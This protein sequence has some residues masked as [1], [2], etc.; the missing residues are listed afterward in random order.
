MNRYHLTTAFDHVN[1]AREQV[2]FDRHFFNHVD[3]HVL[4]RHFPPVVVSKEARRGRD[5]SLRVG[6]LSA[7]AAVAG[8]EGRD[9]GGGDCGAIAGPRIGSKFFDLERQVEAALTR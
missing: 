3:M 9:D 2:S 6:D 1:A 7:A 8:S 5:D 4:T